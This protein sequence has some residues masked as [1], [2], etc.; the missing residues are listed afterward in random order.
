MY[1]HLMRTVGVSA[2]N[3]FV[4][5]KGIPRL[6]FCDFR[7]ETMQRSCGENGLVGQRAGLDGHATGIAWSDVEPRA[8]SVRSSRLNVLRDTTRMCVIAMA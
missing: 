1:D 8:H 4:E 5:R 2:L 3:M 7:E 6:P